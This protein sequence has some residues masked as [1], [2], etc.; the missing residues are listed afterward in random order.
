MVVGERRDQHVG[1]T[2]G[3]G[4]VF[5]PDSQ[6]VA[7]KVVAIAATADASQM[8]GRDALYEAVTEIVIVRLAERRAFVRT[9]PGRQ[10]ARSQGA[11]SVAA[12]PLSVAVSGGVSQSFEAVA[13]H[14]VVPVVIVGAQNR[15]PGQGTRAFFAG[16]GVTG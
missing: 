1:G 4:R 10:A 9:E 6:R 8:V 7:R 13:L 5:F 16:Q 14:K 3:T 2:S 12:A 15:G 11:G